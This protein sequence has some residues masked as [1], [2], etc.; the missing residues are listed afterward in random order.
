MVGIDGSPSCFTAPPGRTAPHPIFA[1]SRL[2]NDELPTA[3]QASEIAFNALPRS[4]AATVKSLSAR[5][6][7]TRSS[8][9]RAANRRPAI[10][11]PTSVNPG[12]TNRGGEAGH[13]AE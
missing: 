2:T 7:G 12:D 1:L 13:V 9:P 5:R 3:T 6:P 11:P 4:L 8:A 10:T